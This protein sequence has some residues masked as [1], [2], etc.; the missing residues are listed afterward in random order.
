MTTVA[1]VTAFLGGRV[2]HTTPGCTAAAFII[3]ATLLGAECCYFL[4]GVDL[5]VGLTNPFADF[6]QH[7]RA[8]YITVLVRPAVR[9]ARGQAA[10][11]CLLR[12]TRGTGGG[13]GQL[14]PDAGRGA[15]GANRLRH[16]LDSHRVRACAEQSR[17]HSRECVR[18]ARP[19]YLLVLMCCPPARRGP[20][21]RNPMLW[22]FFY[23]PVIIIFFVSVAA[24]VRTWMALRSGLSETCVCMRARAR[25]RAIAVWLC[26]TSPVAATRCGFVCCATGCD[27]L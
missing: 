10:D 15:D 2:Q 18:M 4:L 20:Q 7:M 21:Q 16:M 24:H 6:K 19:R 5:F 17:W 27:T 22:A 3:Q 11:C 1:V 8:Y 26:L 12:C 13:A 9:P 14:L 23:I 25:D